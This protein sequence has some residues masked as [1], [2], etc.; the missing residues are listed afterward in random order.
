MEKTPSK[1][2]RKKWRKLVEEQAEFFDLKLRDLMI[3][4]LQHES[5]MRKQLLRRAKKRSTS[6]IT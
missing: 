3:K 6:Y 1:R 5:K 2:E 4:E